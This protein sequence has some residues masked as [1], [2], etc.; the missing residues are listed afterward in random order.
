MLEKTNLPGYM[1][2]INTGAVINTN[3]DEW[4]LYQDQKKQFKEFMR[5]KA[6]LSEMKS[7]LAAIKKALGINV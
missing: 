4:H 5:L 6:E 1:K 2:D 7:D 3:Q